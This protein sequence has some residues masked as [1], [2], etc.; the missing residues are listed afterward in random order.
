V[1][2]L[3]GLEWR[4]NTLGTEPGAKSRQRVDHSGETGESSKEDQ[5]STMVITH[6]FIVHQGAPE[7]FEASQH[8][9]VVG[10]ALDDMGEE[11]VGHPVGQ[12]FRGYLFDAE[13]R[14]G[15]TQ[16]T[17]D[18]RTGPYVLLVAVDPSSRGL[19]QYRQP[20]ILH[21]MARQIRSHRG[22]SLP[23]TLCFTTDSDA[24]FHFRL[25]RQRVHARRR[26]GKSV[27]TNGDHKARVEPS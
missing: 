16:I 26:P 7:L 12:I 17:R 11:H 19:N 18:G 14:L 15:I 13:D 9:H 25:R 2:G 23:G 27:S 22:S 1:R 5:A 8:G 4:T 6:Q 3:D 10:L 21:E 24:A 20:G